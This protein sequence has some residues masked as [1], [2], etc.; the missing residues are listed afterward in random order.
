MS[1]VIGIDLGTTN[2]V[3]AVMEGGMPVVI[4]NSEGSRL[5]SSVVAVTD[6]GE[7]LVGELARRRA[8]LDPLNTIFSIK[9]FMG[10]KLC[11]QSVQYDQTWAPYRLTAASNGDVRV[12]VNGRAY[13][14]PEISAMILRK[15]KQDAEA[16][17]GEPVEKAV[18][19]VP[20]Y[21]N[22]SQRQATKEAGRIAGLEVLRI[23]NEPTA[24]ALAYDFPPRRQMTIAVYDLG[25]GT[26]DISILD[27]NHGVFET[28]STNGDTHLGGDDMD[29]RVVD[30]ICDNFAADDG[31]DL[32]EDR[33]A[34]QRL[35]EAAEQAKI[36]LSTRLHTEINLPFIAMNGGEPKHL[37]MPLSRSELERLV[38]DLVERTAGPCRQA[39]A[40][41][42]LRASDIDEVV[43]V[44]GL[45]RMPAVQEKIKE[46]FGKILYRDINPE[47]AVGL[48]AGIQAGVLVGEVKDVLLIDVTPLTL[49]VE[50]KGGVASPL[51]R[52]NA[53]IPVRKGQVFTTARDD[54]TGVEIHV[55]QGERPMA[56]ENISLGRFILDSIPPAP[57][58]VPRI[59]VT[60]KLDADGILQVAARDKA[61]GRENQITITAS[62]G[63]SEEEVER[64]VAESEVYAE[65]D[66]SRRKRTKMLNLADSMAYQAER[67]LRRCG[68]G[69]LPARTRGEIEGRVAALR[70]TL[71][72]EE[73]ERETIWNAM[74]QLFTVMRELVTGQQLPADSWWHGFQLSR[75]PIRR[76][77]LT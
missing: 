31:I 37:H 49:S 15:M 74:E 75:K 61:T 27:L 58:G 12:N 36:E 38:A 22:D 50:T 63:L 53:T 34:M 5:T 51:I 16:Y 20:A 56:V 69:L 3:M 71:Q 76:E 48:G 29:R 10:R 30:W 41:A 17:L 77:T 11:D 32:R 24:S 64:M 67:T 6:N 40:D 43:L 14:P 35:R 54:Q 1:K 25:G 57:R 46:I 62:S 7:R 4:P 72:G 2:S 13:A 59:E 28:L 26:F 42:G 45:T 8:V 19:T 60:F 33:V 23:L 65:R 52:R 47:E 55:V 66:R 70:A 44:G 39:L 18:I 73:I 21:F 9:R 68:D